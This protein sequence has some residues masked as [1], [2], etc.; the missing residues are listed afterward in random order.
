MGWG[1]EGSIR[2]GRLFRDWDFRQ[3]V[4]DSLEKIRDDDKCY[5]AKHNAKYFLRITDG[6]SAELVC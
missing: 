2:G 5:C 6:R 1:G 4:R 3:E